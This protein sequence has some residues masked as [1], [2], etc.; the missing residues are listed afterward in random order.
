MNGPQSNES[1]HFRVKTGGLL[2]CNSKTK[3]LRDRCRTPGAG[4]RVQLRRITARVISEIRITYDHTLLLPKWTFNWNKS[5]SHAAKIT[6]TIFFFLSFFFAIVRIDLWGNK[7]KFVW[8]CFFFF[9]N[10]LIITFREYS[11]LPLSGENWGDGGAES[12]HST[13]LKGAAHC[14]DSVNYNF[15]KIK[16]RAFT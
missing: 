12:T 16:I 2:L 5:G 8:F 14:K 15:L 13:S 3:T 11:P 4:R 7:E 10:Y 9:L 6:V 1:C